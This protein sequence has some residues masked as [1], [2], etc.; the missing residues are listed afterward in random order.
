MT[1]TVTINM[2]LI[3]EPKM[4]CQKSSTHPVSIDEREH[5][6][7]D[8]VIEDDLLVFVQNLERLR[9]GRLSI[10]NVRVEEIMAER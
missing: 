5:S 4:E 8:N 3:V 9:D 6:K 7:R 2:T 1:P 10:D